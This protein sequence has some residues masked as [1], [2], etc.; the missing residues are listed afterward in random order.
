MTKENKA[1]K[2]AMKMVFDE[3]VSMDDDKFHK[4]IEKHKD[5]DIASILLESGALDVNDQLIEYTEVDDILT[6]FKSTLLN[7]T[8]TDIEKEL[9]TAVSS[10]A[11]T[12]MVIETNCEKEG[13]WSNGLYLDD[14]LDWKADTEISH[15]FIQNIS[16]EDYLNINFIPSQKH[17]VSY[18]EDL[19]EPDDYCPYSLA[20]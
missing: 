20:A 7:W 8:S 5:G 4:E 12:T 16:F 13:I 1:L 9:T 11:W 3:I 18:F 19:K 10:T 2:K 6:T 15:T 17:I 14:V